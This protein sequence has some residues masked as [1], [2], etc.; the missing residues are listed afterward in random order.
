MCI[1]GGSIVK[2]L[3][4]LSPTAM[5]FSKVHVFFANERIGEYKCYKGAIES[6]VDKCKIPH[7]QVEQSLTTDL[8]RRGVESFFCR[9]HKS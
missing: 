4:T 6:F 8:L 5:D 7:S 2:A 3:E 9:S 1:P